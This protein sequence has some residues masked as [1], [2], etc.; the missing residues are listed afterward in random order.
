MDGGEHIEVGVSV[1][2]IVNVNSNQNHLE[3]AMGLNSPV[4]GEPTCFS[5]FPHSP[6]TPFPSPV[7]LAEECKKATKIRTSTSFHQAPHPFSPPS[8]LPQSAP[9]STRPTTD[10]TK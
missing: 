7:K 5:S 9:L 2:V 6:L 3:L 4:P 10:S 1:M 8:L